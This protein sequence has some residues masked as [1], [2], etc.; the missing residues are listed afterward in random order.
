MKGA[1]GGVRAGLGGLYLLEW[2]AYALTAIQVV[3]GHLCKA[4][5]LVSGRSSQVTT[6]SVT[7]SGQATA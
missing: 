4:K 5:T 1:V 7:L 2:A 3:T 6:R